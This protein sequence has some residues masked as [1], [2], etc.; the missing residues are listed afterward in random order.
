MDPLLSKLRDVL[1][2]LGSAAS[3]SSL[4]TKLPPERELA[5][6]LG[7]QRS[8][9]RERLA[10]LEQLGVLKRMQGSGTYVSLPNS[11]FIRF[12]FDLA[13][14]LG[15]ISVEEL[16]V[17]R[18]AL[19]R[20]IARRAAK[21]ASADDVA[22][23]DRLARQMLEATDAQDRLEA[24]Y[25]FHLRLAA[26][27][28]NPVISI[29]IDGLSN[30]LRRTLY[31]RHFLVRSVPGAAKR[32]DASHGPLVE[33]IRAR[34]PE[35]AL[36][37]MDAHFRIWD[38]ESSKV[39]STHHQGV[40]EVRHEQSPAEPSALNNGAPKPRA[41]RRSGVSAAGKPSGRAR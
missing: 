5:A 22:E 6:R 40:P 30:V 26:S 16:H 36:A 25:R 35:A 7:V 12:Y 4:T 3:S 23:L 21:M 39:L 41:R 15:L 20:E 19:E 2:E 18:E 38:E 28:R 29:I 1:L 17:A 8:T 14:A 31:Q 27:A 9:L 11:E 10:M 32:T 13:L 24:D 37:A 34:D 33:A